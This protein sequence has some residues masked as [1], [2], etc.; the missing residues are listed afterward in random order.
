MKIQ[1]NLDND[2]N[3]LPQVA[4]FVRLY[5]FDDEQRIVLNT[6]YGV[7][8]NDSFTYGTKTLQLVANNSALVDGPTGK[9]CDADNPNAI[10]IY[11]FFMK[12]A[13]A[14]PIDLPLLIQTYMTYAKEQGKYN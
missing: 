9:P 3:N 2:A 4:E 11:D 10:G 5:W 6:Q 12:M 1:I 8:Q 7:Y 13:F 14:G